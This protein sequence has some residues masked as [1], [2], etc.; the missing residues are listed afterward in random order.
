MRTILF[1]VVIGAAIAVAAQGYFKK[2]KAVNNTDAVLSAAEMPCGVD[3]TNLDFINSNFQDIAF[4]YVILPGNDDSYVNSVSKSVDYAVRVINESGV[5]AASFIVDDDSPD[6]EQL[7]MYFNISATPAV[8]AITDQLGCNVV[9]GMVDQNSLLRSY[10][11]AS[12]PASGCGDCPG[13]GC[14]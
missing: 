5:N 11:F 8:V 7:K 2:N 3:G 9:A 13:G 12:K 4:A 1:V 10:V 14:E 6:C